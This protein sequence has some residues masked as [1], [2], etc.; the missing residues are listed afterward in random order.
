MRWS[1]IRTIWLRELR[2]QL[3]D[4]RTIFMI[5]ALPLLLYPVLGVIVLKLV[6]AFGSTPS[7]IGIVTGSKDTKDFPPRDP[8]GAGRSP[9]PALAWFAATPLPGA[10]IT[11]W[12]GAAALAQADHIVFDYPFLIH[13]GRFTTF[14]RTK[15]RR[16]S[17]ESMNHILI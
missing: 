1:I 12:T 3:R 13:D 16:Q 11:Q 6:V 2:D 10:D 4:R 7:T 15:S 9:L 14:D 17:R 8:P 5:V